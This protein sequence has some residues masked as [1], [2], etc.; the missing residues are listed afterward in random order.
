LA[1]ELIDAVEQIEHA[2]KQ[3]EGDNQTTVQKLAN[4]KG[5]LDTAVGGL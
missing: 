2:L 5:Q 4:A 1:V 3:Y